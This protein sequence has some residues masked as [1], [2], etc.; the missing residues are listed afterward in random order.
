MMGWYDGYGWSGWMFVMMLGWPLL[1]GLAAWAV[2]VLTRSGSGPVAGSQGGA[3]NS[4]DA[5]ARSVDTSA[6][7]RQPV[8]GTADR[9]VRNGSSA[10]IVGQ[11]PE[12]PEEILARRFASGEI[13]VGEFIRARDILRGLPYDNAPEAG[14]APPQEP[15]PTASRPI[16]GAAVAAH[17]GVVPDNDSG[18]GRRAE[19]PE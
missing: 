14:F 4:S 10:P 19:S 8:A 5:S 6:T 2:V 15:V 3:H 18:M 11:H 17:R 7:G 1:L 12:T 9:R 16:G 13:S